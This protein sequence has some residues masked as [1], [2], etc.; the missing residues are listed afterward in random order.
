MGQN[1]DIDLCPTVYNIELSIKNN[2]IIKFWGGLNY[3]SGFLR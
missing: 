2:Y 3:L 1:S